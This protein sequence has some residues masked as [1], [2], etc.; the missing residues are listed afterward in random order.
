MKFIKDFYLF[1][2]RIATHVIFWV[3]YYILF[4]FVWVA[5]DGYL[6]S[7]Y[8][9]FILLPTR[10][11]AVYVVIYFLLPRFLLKRKYTNFFLGYVIVLLLAGVLQRVF[12]HLFYE[13]L[14]LNNV[15]KGLFSI[16]MLVRAV[17]L[18]NTT[19][20][21]VLGAKLFQL[22]LIE[23]EKNREVR[24]EYLEIRSNRRI[25]R[26]A[27]DNILF[28]EGLG[29]YVNYHLRDKSKVTAYATI[30]DTLV[31]LPENF[32]RV[33]RSYIVNKDH[34]K[35]YD[36]NTIDVENQMVPRGKSVTDEVLL[37]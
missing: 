27:T 30:K 22:W 24:Q 19:V 17:V 12:I 16:N 4:G 28:V 20:L 10:I 33:H 5:E 14:L 2:S 15:E 23:H 29:N 36:A 26:I 9:E 6:A 8:L 37:T 34:I 32:I 31:L 1:N 11:L 3:A 7:F 21:L 18:I 13:N 25:H 35:S